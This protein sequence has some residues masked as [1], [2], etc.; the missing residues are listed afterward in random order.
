MLA[1]SIEDKV[2]ATIIKFIIT[3]TFIYI[4]DDGIGMNINEINNMWDIFRENNSEHKSL[5]ISGLGAKAATKILS[6]D[7]E[8]LYYTFNNSQW[9]KI[10]V[11]WN[12]IVLNNIYTDQVIVDNINN[13]DENELNNLGI[14]KGTTLR[15][16]YDEEI[17]DLI[18]NNF[19]E[20]RKFLLY[21]ERFDVIFGRFNKT[22][23][24]IDNIEID[25]SSIINPYNYFSDPDV[26]FYKGINTERIC[27][28]N[29]N[30]KIKF[31]W[32][33][34]ENNDDYREIVKTGGGLSKTSK[35]LNFQLIGKYLVI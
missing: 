8:I 5:G 3:D 32:F 2:Q 1:N 29:D 35:K 31:I 26:C 30:E 23:E 18:K 17:H 21:H 25:N 16:P 24:L 27:V 20:N 7:N 11:P 33:K 28:I 19:S 12:N 6:R 13:D 4:V 9:K 34:D 22:I 10:T 15:I 14:I